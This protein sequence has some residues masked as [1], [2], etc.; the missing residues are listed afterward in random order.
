M[1]VLRR[2]FKAESN[3]YAR[4]IREELRIPLHGPL[5]P[6][7]L[8]EHLSYSVIRLSEFL[9]AQP[10]AV[11]YLM[12]EIGQKG[13]SAITLFHEDLRWI[14]HNDAHEVDRQRSNISHELAHGLLLH[15][16]APLRGLDGARTFNAEQEAEAHW[17]GPA[18]LVS[19]EAALHIVR[20]RMSQQLALATYGVS[21]ELLQMRLNVTGALI[22]KNRRRAA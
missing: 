14:V 17:L 3:W 21:A 22:R 16:P 20:S 13:F 2:G 11:Q 19:Q 12:S 15:S 4:Q 18:L 5:C 7:R 9:N 6:W 1:I 8:A 10:D